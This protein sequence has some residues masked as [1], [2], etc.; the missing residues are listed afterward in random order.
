VKEKERIDEYVKQQ[1]ERH[2][3]HYNPLETRDFIDIYLH[4]VNNNSDSDIPGIV[5]YAYIFHWFILFFYVKLISY[6]G[7]DHLT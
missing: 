2:K 3:I 5:A 7:I 4:H 6:L 1:I